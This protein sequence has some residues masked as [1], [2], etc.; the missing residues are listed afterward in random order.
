MRDLSRDFFLA[1]GSITINYFIL[2]Q[3]VTV[4]AQKLVNE[5]VSDSVSTAKNI[6]RAVIKLAAGL[7]P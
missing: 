4:E 6:L 5:S 7:L 1:N 2:W 3:F